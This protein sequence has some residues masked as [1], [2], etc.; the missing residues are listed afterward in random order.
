MRLSVVC[1]AALHK[2]AASCEAAL[3]IVSTTVQNDSETA[4]KGTGMS[5]MRLFF[6][7]TAKLC[8]RKGFLLL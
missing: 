2:L 4:N 8:S 3:Q 6:R 5:K 1:E 7:G